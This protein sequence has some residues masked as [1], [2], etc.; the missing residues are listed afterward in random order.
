MVKLGPLF[1]IKKT[2]YFIFYGVAK[3]AGMKA[4]LD[5]ILFLPD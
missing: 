4:D 5:Y 2:K 1:H 3:S